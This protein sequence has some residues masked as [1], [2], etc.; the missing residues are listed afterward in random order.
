MTLC[1]GKR[2]LKAP[3]SRCGMHLEV[4]NCDLYGTGDNARIFLLQSKLSDPMVENMSP[5]EPV[6]ES[7]LG[8]LREVPYMGVIFVVAEAMK[9]GF[10]NGHPDWC[11]LGQGQPEV[12]DMEGAPPRIGSVSILPE[13]HAYGPLGGIPELRA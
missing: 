2:D 8:A 5:T 4:A 3:T 10:V 12:G 1:A 6:S 7:A 13:D 11:N 9:L